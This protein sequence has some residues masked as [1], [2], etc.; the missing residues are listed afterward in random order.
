MKYKFI[1]NSIVQ[2]NRIDEV[3]GNLLRRILQSCSL[4]VGKSNWEII[5]GLV[6]I[7]VELCQFL[8]IS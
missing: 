3:V 1:G 5:V 2:Y 7:K 6:R 8:L 4:R